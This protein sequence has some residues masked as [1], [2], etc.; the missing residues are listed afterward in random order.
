MAPRWSC[1]CPTKDPGA[2][3]ISSGF[4]ETLDSP[5]TFSGMRRALLLLVL[6]MALSAQSGAESLVV[7]SSATPCLTVRRAPEADA[8]TLACLVPGTVVTA[9][10]AE[11]GRAHV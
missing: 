8:P 5:A 7:R 6:P 3:A 9:D 1:W 2:P 10:S 4:A 11:I